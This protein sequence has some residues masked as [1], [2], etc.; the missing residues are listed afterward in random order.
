MPTLSGD[1]SPHELRRRDGEDSLSLS[2]DVGNMVDMIRYSLNV[3]QS[4]IRDELRGE[5]HLSDIAA[6]RADTSRQ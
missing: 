5:V 4:L 3:R 6:V 1:A 2:G